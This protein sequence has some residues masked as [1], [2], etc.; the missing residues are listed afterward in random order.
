MRQTFFKELVKLAEK[1]RDVMFLTGDLGFSYFEEFRGK[2]PDQFI[3]CGITEQSMVGIAA[4]LA[5]GGKKP[6]C[7]S[8]ISILLYRTLEQI[9]NDICYADL[10]VK[11]IGYEGTE[12]LDFTHNLEGT[13]NEEDLLKNLPNLKRYYPKNP[14]ELEKVMRKSYKSQR[15]AYVH[16]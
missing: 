9:R 2:F 14:A 16:L 12:F 7:Y 6:Y 3:N 8:Y 10:N 15:P 13:E 1:D 11:L 4:G 5:L